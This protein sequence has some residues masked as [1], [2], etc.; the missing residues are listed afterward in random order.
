MMKFG[1]T[2]FFAFFIY[3]AYSQ[4]VPRV[5][6]NIFKDDKG[7][8]LVKD[9]R[10]IY[11][12][13]TKSMHTLSQMQGEIRATNVGLYFDFLSPNLR[14]TL[15]YGFIPY[16]D[17]KH[18]Q[19]VFFKYNAEIFNGKSSID[20]INNMDGRYD[21]VG[22]EDGKQATLGYRIVDDKGK[23]LYQGKIEFSYNGSS[24]KTKKTLTEGPFLADET[25][26]SCTIWFRTD[27]NLK[28]KLRINGE[29]LKSQR[30]KNHEFT[31]NNL[32]P[33]T[34]YAYEIE[35]G[36]EKK[37]YG[38]TTPPEIGRRKPFVFGYASDSRAGN[39]GGERN[40][41]GTNYYIMRKIMA[42]AKSQ[43]VA[44]MQFT[45]DLI[46]GYS[47]NADDMNLQY[48]N[49]RR[50]I[51][52][53]ASDL[54]IYTTMG[55]HE[56]VMIEFY[57]SIKR[58][59]YFIDAFPFE[60]LSAEAIFAN[61]F[62]NP[63][64]GP[65]SEDG[66]S[67]D[68][69]PNERDFPDYAETVY[70]YVYDNVAIIVLNSNYLY[71]PSLARAP[72]TSG[73]LH[74]YIMEQQMNWLEKTVLK[75]NADTRI[76]HIFITVHTPV[77]PNGGHVRDDMWYSGKNKYRAYINGKKLEKGIIEKRDQILNIAI[78][79]SN[80]TVAFLTG[81]EHNYSR[82]RITGESNI[83]PE[84][85]RSTKLKIKRPFYQ[86]N[87]GA[88]GAPYY[89]QETTP[90]Q[91]YLERFSTQN[92]LVLFYIDGKTVKLKV[93]NPDTLEI[94]DECEIKK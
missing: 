39:G 7:L 6:S 9:G 14:G 2:V 62:V 48:A 16:D 88:A 71:A 47:Q 60:T 46:N 29:T 36:G 61:N 15:Y 34:K 28:A 51:E 66:S 40:L 20:I 87:N 59:R 86:I 22:W 35:Y 58:K 11:Q 37:N 24:I 85:Y 83:Y 56:V 4:D 65:V 25:P 67:F 23:M 43:D 57:D 64:N 79:S 81:D 31:I 49:W 74:G 93:I 92:A 91:E 78:N 12:R 1:L 89:A 70:D 84:K 27:K 50:S 68:P 19:P 73:N 94:V 76:D 32:I 3:W 80:K 45:G 33:E 63:K 53:Y 52:A 44:F 21:I 69:N 55:N 17:S 18:P 38:F 41:Y 77:F 26:N 30:S 10:Q 8:F 42:Y 75:H 90:W 72:I 5:Y 82:L 13:K 54:P